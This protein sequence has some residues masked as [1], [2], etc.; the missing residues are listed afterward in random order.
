MIFL[1]S[2]ANAATL[3]PEALIAVTLFPMQF[4]RMSYLYFLVQACL[5]YWPDVSPFD[6][7]GTTI[8]LAFVVLMAGIKT[9]AGKVVSFRG[10]NV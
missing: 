10:L 4:S 3:S 7:W 8:A 9:A 2:H 6:P 1:T 5:T